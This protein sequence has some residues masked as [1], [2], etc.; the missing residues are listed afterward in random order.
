MGKSVL[1]PSVTT[2]AVGEDIT[3]E[4]YEELIRKVGDWFAKIRST[5]EPVAAA[6]FAI[7]ACLAGVKPSDG[8]TPWDSAATATLQTR[9]K[10]ACRFDLETMTPLLSA[11]EKTLRKKANEKARLERKKEE[12]KRDPNLPEEYREAERRGVETT[13]V[14]AADVK[15]G[16][17]PLQLFTTAELA[18]REALRQAFL[19]D[20]PELKNVAAHAK[21]DMLLDNLLFI[22][23]HRLRKAKDQDKSEYK[24][25]DLIRQNLELE[26]AL[27]IHPD[28]VRKRQKEREGGTVGEAVRRLED[29]GPTHPLRKKWFVE[30]LLLGFQAASSPSPRSDREGYQLD[31]A[32][33]FAL[34]KCRTCHCAT[35]GTRNFAG[36]TYDEVEQWLA[37]NSHLTPAESPVDTLFAIARGQVDESPPEAIA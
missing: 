35:C 17:D 16:E 15:Y 7:D 23:R 33:L 20:F 30:E 4:R 19:K 37:A 1:R 28:Q 25:Q 10:M 31:Q 21:L 9:L 5:K 27:D 26:K 13:G 34:T 6:K 24:I 14:R 29:M 18:R 2:Y 3:P 11:S 32:G 22:E 36:F 12:A 8:K